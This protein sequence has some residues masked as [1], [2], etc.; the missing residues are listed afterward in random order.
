VDAVAEL[1]HALQ[2]RSSLEVVEVVT[3]DVQE[4]H[5]A[6]ELRDEV[7]IPELVEER[8]TRHR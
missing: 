3:V 5:P 4:G 7:A 6:T 2:V 8:A 1:G